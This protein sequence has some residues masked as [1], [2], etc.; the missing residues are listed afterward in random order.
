[1]ALLDELVDVEVALVAR[2]LDVHPILCL[3]RWDDIVE[4]SVPNHLLT[5]DVVVAVAFVV[6]LVVD[7]VVG[8]TSFNRLMSRSF[9]VSVLVYFW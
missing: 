4:T 1:M 9:F 5:T 3:P 6:Y 7:E 2:M 8:F